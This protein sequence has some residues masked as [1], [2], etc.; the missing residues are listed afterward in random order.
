MTMSVLMPLERTSGHLFASHRGARYLLDTGSPQSFGTVGLLEISGQ[1]MSL[2]GSYGGLDAHALSG[3]VHSRV[4][5]LLGADVLGRF[6]LRID[7][8]GGVVEWSL[9]DMA[10]EGDQLALAFVMGV[11]VVEVAIGGK[12]AAMV[13]DTGAQ[14]SY[15]QDESLFDYESVGVFS[16]FYPGFGGFDTHTC[17]VP[18]RLGAVVKNLRCG[19]LPE[20]LGMTLMLT[21]AQGIVGNE[22]LADRTA[23][24]LPRRAKLVL[25]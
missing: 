7:V 19:A 14:I 2:P 6:D 18:M 8:A 12:T 24:Y 25:A 13:F 3:L 23:Y 10:P 20:L 15:W 21:G 16:D 4:D 1:S 17:I 9:E 11:P 22:V 5:G